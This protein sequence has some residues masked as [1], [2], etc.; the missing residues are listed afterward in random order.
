M[1][2]A[3]VTH[4][5]LFSYDT[6]TYRPWIISPANF[7]SAIVASFL[8]LMS[9]GGNPARNST[10]CFEHLLATNAYITPTRSDSENRRS[11]R[12]P[13]GSL[14]CILTAPGAPSSGSSVSAYARSDIDGEGCSKLAASAICNIS[15]S[16]IWLVSF[17]P[18][19]AFPSSRLP[20]PTSFHGLSAR[21]MAFDFPLIK[22]SSF[23]Q[24]CGSPR[25][26]MASLV[27]GGGSDFRTQNTE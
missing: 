7:E 4:S 3:A 17:P 18:L 9:L 27:Q 19:T 1:Q 23:H 8:E 2:I 16:D 11:A 5:M 20:L 12:V 26:I 6:Y 10:L 15:S 21:V 22:S 24:Y 25:S 13:S 14:N